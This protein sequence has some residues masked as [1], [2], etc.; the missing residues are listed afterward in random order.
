[1]SERVTNAASSGGGEGGSAPHDGAGQEGKSAR[2]A[3]FDLLVFA[4]L[5]LAATAAQE[6]PHMAEEGRRRLAGHLTNARFVGKV[7]LTVGRRKAE[8][9]LREVEGMAGRL[10]FEDRSTPVT[11][12][13]PAA[14]HEPAPPGRPADAATGPA[15]PARRGAPAGAPSGEG[16]AIP[17]F[18]ALSA[19]QVVQRLAGLTR[20][21][22]EDVREYEEG[23][24]RRRMVL[25]CVTQLLGPD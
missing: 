25:A 9:K 7:A 16:L 15:A 8:G 12:R 21:E 3:L 14:P 17:G 13:P 6:L 10:L 5:G 18:D 2:D 11:D 23:H 19:S 24:R 22:L 1:M 20:S 4:P